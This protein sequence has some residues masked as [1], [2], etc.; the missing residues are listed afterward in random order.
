MKKILVIMSIAIA[1]IF[2]VQ[3]RNQVQAH[4]TVSFSL[5]FDALAPYGNWMSVPDY[6]YVWQ[7]TYVG[8]GWRPYSLIIL[9]FAC[10][11]GPLGSSSLG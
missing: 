7:P 8:Q 4:T 2:G 10:R 3:D 11:I 1:I 9:G 5:F 6:G